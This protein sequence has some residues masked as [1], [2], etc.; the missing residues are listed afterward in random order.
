MLACRQVSPA[1]SRRLVFRSEGQHILVPGIASVCEL[2]L[3]VFVYQKC[4]FGRFGLGLATRLTSCGADS[5]CY[6]AETK[7]GIRYK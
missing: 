6:L 1:K 3:E 2:Y 7:F 5:T 4:L